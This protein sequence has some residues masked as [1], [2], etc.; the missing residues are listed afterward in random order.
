MADA[1]TQVERKIEIAKIDRAQRVVYAWAY[2]ARDDAGR[3]PEDVTGQV[4]ADPIEV[5]KMAHRFSRDILS[6]AVQYAADE[7]HERPANGQLVAT[8]PI[9]DETARLFASDKGEVTKRRGWVV[10]FQF[11]PGRTWDRIASGELRELSWK[12]RAAGRAFD[13]KRF[14]AA[15]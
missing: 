10:G 7:M 5:E 3:I 9:T 12:G 13:A 2:V 8:F 1:P 11:A 15:A 14:E 4:M 6:G